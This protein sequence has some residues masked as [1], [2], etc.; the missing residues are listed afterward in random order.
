M[1]EKDLF[2]DQIDAHPL[3]SRCIEIRLT[4]QGLAQGFAERAKQIAEIEGLDGQ[5]VSAYVA[6]A[7]KHKNNMR[8]M[9]QTVESGAMLE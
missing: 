3:L 5:P 4:N 2:D 9:L 1:A 7:R 8:A 6:L